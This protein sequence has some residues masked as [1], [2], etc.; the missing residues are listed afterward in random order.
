MNLIANEFGELLNIMKEVAADKRVDNSHLVYFSGDQISIFNGEIY[1]RKDFPTEFSGA[2]TLG[3][4]SSIVE[5]YG[6]N[7]IDLYRNEG[8]AISVKHKRSI[9]KLITE[10]NYK[11]PELIGIENKKWKKLPQNF[12]KTLEAAVCVTTNNISELIKSCIHVKG[13]TIEAGDGFK[14]AVYKLNESVDDEMF[15]RRDAVKFLSK[16]TPSEY[17]ICEDWV[18]FKNEKGIY[19]SLRKITI[20]DYPNME[21]IFEENKGNS[22]ITI[23][24]KLITSLEKANIFMQSEF[25][26]NR[27]V[28][29]TIDGERLKVKATS[30]N[31]SYSDTIKIEPSTNIVFGINPQNLIDMLMNNNKFE[32]GEKSIIMT[33]KEVKYLSCLMDTKNLNNEESNTQAE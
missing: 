12:I 28:I 33:S 15:I 10:D 21:S 25:E 20:S 30:A 6:T 24:D 26:Y 9:S 17:T 14:V 8:D 16:L 2:V 27:F 23:P 18:H 3:L 1:A 29:I 7:E 11:C 5:K 19:S 13:E 22:T 31:G 4:L 32:V